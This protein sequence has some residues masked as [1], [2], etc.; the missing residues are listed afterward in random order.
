MRI[1]IENLKF[2]TIVGVY[3]QERRDEQAVVVDIRIDYAF[4]N[5]SYIDYERVSKMVEKCMKQKKFRL[6]EEAIVFIKD[7]L[8]SNFQYINSIYIKI[9]KPQILSNCLVGVEEFF[10]IR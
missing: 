8:T 9:S 3:P 2:N 1:L 5:G 6:L 4:S 10:E 7:M